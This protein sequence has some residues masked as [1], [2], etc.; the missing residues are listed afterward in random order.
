MISASLLATHDAHSRMSS[1]IWSTIK[2]NTSPALHFISSVGK[3]LIQAG[4]MS[5]MMLHT[6]ATGPPGPKQVRKSR[7]VV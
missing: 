1:V 6:Q 3:L 4:F 2:P 7:S 5:I